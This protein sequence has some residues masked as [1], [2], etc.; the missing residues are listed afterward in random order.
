[1]FLILQR[2]LNENGDHVESNLYIAPGADPAAQEEKQTKLST[3]IQLD[4]I[5]FV[6]CKN[7]PKQ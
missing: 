3:I 6:Y 4:A 5:P 2:D 1:M 7:A